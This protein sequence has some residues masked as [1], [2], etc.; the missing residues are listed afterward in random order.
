MDGNVV[1]PATSKLR[2]RLAREVNLGR[3]LMRRRLLS[4]AR[5]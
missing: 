5:S 4:R 1:A 3:G 2:R